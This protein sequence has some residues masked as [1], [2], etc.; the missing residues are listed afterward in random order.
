MPKRTKCEWCGKSTTKKQIYEL[1]K[2]DIFLPFKNAPSDTVWICEYCENGADIFHCEG[3]SRTVFETNG[4]MINYRIVH[5]DTQLCLR[6]FEAEYLE[7]GM[8]LFEDEKPMGLHGMFFSQGDPEPL[9]AGYT[10]HERS[11]FVRHDPT[12]VIKDVLKLMDE[13]YKVVIGY[14]RLSIVGDEG[15]ISIF[16]KKEDQDENR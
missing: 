6:C 13:G 7:Q 2:V 9:T 15:W 4:H 11:I 1:N 12:P 10:Y 16:K 5:G 3:C 8:A 14:E